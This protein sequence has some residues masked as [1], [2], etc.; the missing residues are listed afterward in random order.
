MEKWLVTIIKQAI[1]MASPAIIEN[2]RRTVQEIVDHAATTEN[3]WDDILA[4]IL[5]LL[6]GK[7]GD[8]TET[9]E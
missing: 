9:D 2:L 1:K 8:T 5:Q 3:P 7:P 6:V 4:W